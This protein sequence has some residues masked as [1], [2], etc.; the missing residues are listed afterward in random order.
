VPEEVK[1]TRASLR[2]P[3]AAA[4]AGIAFSLIFGTAL[5][6]VRL[7]VPANPD[8]AAAWIDEGWRNTAVTVALYLVPIAGLAFLWFVGVVR[9]RI[10]A[11]EDRLLA[12]VFFGTGLLFVA[13]L[14]VSAAAG[15]ALL[16][17]THH[18]GSGVSS[19]V[20]SFGR[21]SIYLVLTVY[22][23]R[24]AGAFT[25]VT[26]SIAHRLG[27]FP[28]WLLAFGWI[29][30]IVLLLTIESFPWGVMLFPLRV[31][32]ISIHFLTHNPAGNAAE[33]LS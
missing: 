4:V 18:Q 32:V 20:W 3:R 11:A 29:V 33:A 2:T 31:L 23:M 17:A 21:H 16:E 7:A 28:R 19:D 14:F 22:G 6:L 5:V 8:D 26:T 9:D 12:T 13:M 24:M 1:I 30:A 10:G 27:M 25:I 15:G